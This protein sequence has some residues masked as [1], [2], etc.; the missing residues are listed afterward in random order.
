LQFS[1][2]QLQ[3][4]DGVIMDAKSFNF[5]FKC[6]QNGGYLAPHFVFF[7]ENLPTRRKFLDRLFF[8]EWKGGG[9]QLPPS[10]Q[11]ATALPLHLTGHS[12]GDFSSHHWRVVDGHPVYICLDYPV[13]FISVCLMAPLCVI[14][15]SVVCSLTRSVDPHRSVLP[16]LAIAKRI[17]TSSGVLVMDK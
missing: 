3:I 9:A 11:D 13:T 1:D 16:R 8:G 5:F 4:S 10:C 2:R 17:R 15:T 7:D 12:R 6:L 14:S